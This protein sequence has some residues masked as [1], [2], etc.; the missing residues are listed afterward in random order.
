MGAAGRRR[1]EE[2]FTLDGMVNGYE[3]ALG[4]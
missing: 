4:L 2:R 3:Q 1:A